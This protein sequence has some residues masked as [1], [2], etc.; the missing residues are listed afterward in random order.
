MTTTV[1]K[2]KPKYTQV[3]DYSKCNNRI[4]ISEYERRVYRH[5]F[6]GTDCRE[7]WKKENIWR[8]E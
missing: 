1:I 8:K 2:G 7:K 3:C 4:S 5:H 6:C